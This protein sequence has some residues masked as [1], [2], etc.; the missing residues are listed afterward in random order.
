MSS[1]KHTKLWNPVNKT[2]KIS[3]FTVVQV[4][5]NSYSVFNCAMALLFTSN[6][7]AL[8]KIS[9]LILKQYDKLLW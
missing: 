5:L 4:A 3:A 2:K 8:M 6:Y 7:K 1:V 9:K